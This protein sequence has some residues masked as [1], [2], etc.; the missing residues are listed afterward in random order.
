M[1]KLIAF[2]KRDLIDALRFFRRAF[3]WLV[4]P[5]P[6]CGNDP[7]SRCEDCHQNWLKR[8]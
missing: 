1:S 4:P 8:W 5:C 2:L 6:K 7:K 3:D